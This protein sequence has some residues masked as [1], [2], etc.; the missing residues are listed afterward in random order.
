MAGRSGRNRLVGP[1]GGALAV[2]LLCLHVGWVT[3]GNPDS[4]P[5]IDSVSVGWENPVTPTRGADP[6]MEEDGE[7]APAP[8]GNC[9]ARILVTDTAGRPVPGATVEIHRYTKRDDGRS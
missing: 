3:R 1:A 7:D 4:G 5:T 8:E 6:A 2:L 9:R